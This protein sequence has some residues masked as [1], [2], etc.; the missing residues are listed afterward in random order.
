MFLVKEVTEEEA[1]DFFSSSGLFSFS[2]PSFKEWN[3]RMVRAWESDS[4]DTLSLVSERLKKGNF[5]AVQKK[6]RSSARFF[7][8]QY[9][10]IFV[11]WG[12]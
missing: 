2:Y 8:I 9:P 5:F 1:R 3:Q 12:M 7:Q 11:L 4:I 10:D 6:D